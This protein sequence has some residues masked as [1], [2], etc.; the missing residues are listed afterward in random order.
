RTMGVDPP[1]RVMD[2]GCGWGVNLAEM[3]RQGY[4]VTGLD[5]SRRTLEQLDRPGRTLIEADLTQPLPETIEP[6]DALLALDVIEHL[7]D[8]RAAVSQ[9]ARLTRPGGAVIVSVPA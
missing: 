9:F 7:D 4:A 2:A 3:E 5:I 1:A 6:Y 8:D